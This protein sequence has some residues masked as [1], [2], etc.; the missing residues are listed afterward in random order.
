[1]RLFKNYEI[2]DFKAAFSVI[3]IFDIVITK[4]MLLAKS[5]IYFLKLYLMVYII[6]KSQV[7]AFFNHKVR[8]G[9][10]SLPPPPLRNVVLKTHPDKVNL[11]SKDFLQ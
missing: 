10:C 1:M 6:A 5:F 11:S 4:I 2:F 9:R 7:L 8:Y 3:S